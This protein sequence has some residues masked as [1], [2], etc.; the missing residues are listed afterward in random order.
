MADDSKNALMLTSL[1]IRNSKKSFDSAS[2]A[3]NVHPTS[4]GLCGCVTAAF[5]WF[6]CSD[7]PAVPRPAA[8]V[9]KARLLIARRVS[10]PSN[11]DPPQAEIIRTPLSVDHQVSDAVMANVSRRKIAM[12]GGLML[13]TPIR[14]SSDITS[15]KMKR[16]PSREIGYRYE[17][18]G[19]PFAIGGFAEVYKCRDITTK[20]LR[21]AKRVPKDQVS[22]NILLRR[23]LELLLTLDHPNVVRLFEWFETRDSIWLIQELCSGG[24][25]LSLVENCTSREALG[26]IR[27]VLLGLSYL[28]DRGVVHRDIKL[29]NCMF[30]SCTE[31]RFGPGSPLVKI[32]DFGLAGVVRLPPPQ[33]LHHSPRPRSS[34]LSSLSHQLTNYAG[35][36]LYISPESIAN[37]CKEGVVESL[38]K[39]DMWALGILAFIL[40]TGQHPFWDKSQPFDED[41]IRSKILVTDPD[42]SSIEP[43]SA[44][45][46]VSVLLEKNPDRRFTARQ[47]LSHPCMRAS[48]FL[49][50][51]AHVRLL[52][53]LRSFKLYSPLERVVLTIIAYNSSSSETFGGQSLRELFEL[54]DTDRNGVLS[55]S[56]IFSG[57]RRLGFILAP[58]MEEIF[59]SID[60]DGSGEIDYTEFIAAA[61]GPDLVRNPNASD[62]AFGWLTQ[63]SADSIC[64]SD[65]CLVVDTDEAHKALLEYGE[66]GG[67]NLITRTGFSRLIERIAKIKD[68][69]ILV[70]SKISPP[71][72]TSRTTPLVRRMSWSDEL[73]PERSRRKKNF[74][75]TTRSNP[76]TPLRQHSADPDSR[77]SSVRF[78]PGL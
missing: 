70:H 32:I 8:G 38:A 72:P 20:E 1:F 21:V 68:E 7:V 54:L 42:L 24:E 16:D 73:S 35:T 27:Q 55:K 77:I 2:I 49:G 18:L 28:H 45:E 3:M 75:T 76:I 29:E 14:Q 23:E 17:I 26:V 19:E 66:P 69:S 9:V 36:S 57:M 61:I 56:E 60:T 11:D 59:D 52:S 71:S 30:Q 53:H 40:L 48:A 43:E 64:E 46:F 39:C 44:I 65:L 5:R 6:T 12:V 25:I 62:L 63:A 15:L 33:T 37:T 34:S 47:A 41:V 74:N 4:A 13:P 10:E 51:D 67:N 50:S 22:D 31:K 58:D 78:S